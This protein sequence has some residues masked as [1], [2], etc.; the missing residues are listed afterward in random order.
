MT[1]RLTII[2]DLQ[3]IVPAIKG[4][5]IVYAAAWE[6]KSGA[7][8]KRQYFLSSKVVWDTVKRLNRF[9]PYYTAAVAYFEAQFLRRP[10]GWQLLPLSDSVQQPQGRT[11]RTIFY[12]YPSC[13]DMSLF[14][15]YRVSAA[16]F[17]LELVIYTSYLSYGEHCNSE[18]PQR[19][20]GR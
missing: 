8:A 14:T 19:H 3:G 10:Q 15:I 20:S 18:F 9:I 13:T 6:S 16:V 1:R 5:W 17:Q 7:D 2:L 12:P 4:A 11:H